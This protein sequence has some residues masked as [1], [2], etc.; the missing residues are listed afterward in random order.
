MSAQVLKLLHNRWL[1]CV[2]I[3]GY[4]PDLATNSKVAASQNSLCPKDSKIVAKQ[5][6]YR[7]IYGIPYILGV[8]NQVQSALGSQFKFLKSKAK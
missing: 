5:M 2:T 6:K 1:Q 7:C 4:Q 8:F 3:S